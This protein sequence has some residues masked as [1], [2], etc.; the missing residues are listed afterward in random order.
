MVQV[1][2]FQDDVHDAIISQF[3]PLV[4]GSTT[5]YSYLSNVDHVRARGVEVVLGSNNLFVRGLELS[6]QRDVHGRED[7][8]DLGAR[9][10][11]GAGRH[12]DRQAAAEHSEVASELHDDVSP[13]WRSS[14][15]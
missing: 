4:P 14:G 9:E 3:L 1:A 7:A 13:G 8:R 12:R 10:R 11:D 5:L 15:R 6:G 2:L